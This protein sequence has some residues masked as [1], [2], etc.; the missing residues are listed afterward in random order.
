LL[1]GIIDSHQQEPEASNLFDAG[2]EL[3][4]R[5]LNSYAPRGS[6][7]RRPLS[8]ANAK[9]IESREGRDVQE[10]SGDPIWAIW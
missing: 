5:G 3:H 9:S 10:L 6:D 4:S 7:C 1:F 2:S 8:G